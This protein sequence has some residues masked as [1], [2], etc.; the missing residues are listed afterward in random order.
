MPCAFAFFGR[1]VE[2]QLLCSEPDRRSKFLLLFQ[3]LLRN[4]VVRCPSDDDI[5]TNLLDKLHHSSM[6]SWGV[7][8]ACVG[9]W[10]VCRP[11]SRDARAIH[12][13]QALHWR[14]RSS[15]GGRLA[16]TPPIMVAAPPY[17]LACPG[18]ARASKPE[19]S[20]LIEASNIAVAYNSSSCLDAICTVRNIFPMLIRPSSSYV[21]NKM[22]V[23]TS[24]DSSWVPQLCLHFN[25]EA[26]Q[27]M[28]GSL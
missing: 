17:Y 4:L 26:S 28:T 11:F 21:D 16:L 23:C 9:S 25:L 19:S 6:Q 1:S 13:R 22:Q 27:L 8:L 10:H 14:V 2:R 18:L 7:H 5:D 24:Q 3:R 15:R 20:S 12:G